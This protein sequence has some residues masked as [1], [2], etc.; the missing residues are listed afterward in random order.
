VVPFALNVLSHPEY[1]GRG[2]F[3][4]LE[5]ATEEEARRQ[6]RPFMLSFPNAAS[7]P[8]FLNRL[9]WRRGQVAPLMLKVA[10]FDALLSLAPGLALGRR[11]AAALNPV[12]RRW[13]RR[14]I[15]AGVEVIDEFGEEFDR[16]WVQERASRRWGLVR[17][18]T[19]LNWRYLQAP[20]KRYRSH[21]VLDGGRTVGY[22]VSGVI[23]KKGL[24]WGFVA[25]LFVAQRAA[26]RYA[27]ALATVDA[28][29]FREDIDAVVCFAPSRW[30]DLLRH[31]GFVYL[32]TPKR[33]NFIYKVLDPQFDALPLADA[34]RWEFHLGDTDFF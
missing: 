28:F 26:H 18:S 1:R 29:L 25:D 16:L 23:E 20:S 32:P 19:H 34:S 4:A 13:F 27:D 33:F 30:Q 15:P 31:L 12:G 11:L 5:L 10:R 24:R 3:S 2:V 17:D 9:G 8:I 22:V 14:Q 6:G 7:T 21:R